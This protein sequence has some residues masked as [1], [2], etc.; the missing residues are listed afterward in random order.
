MAEE[1]IDA[2]ISA[3]NL[4]AKNGCVTAGLLLEGA[5][6]WNEL[7]YIHLVQDYGIETDVAQHLSNTYGDRAFTVAK[8]SKL[9]K[10]RWPIVGTRL[11]VEFPYLESEV[12]Y[13]IRE[14]AMTAVDVLA[15]RLRLAFLNTYAA[16]EVVEEVV[17]IMAAEL[18]W[19][20]AEKRR[21]I[22]TCRRFIDIEMG[23]N[24]RAQAVSDVTLNLTKKEMQVARERFNLLDKDRKGHITVN[25]L[26][27]YFREHGEKIDERLLHELLN[28][29]DLNKNGE[30]EIMEFLQ[31]Y[32]ALKGGQIAQN[33]LVRYLDEIQTSQSIPVG[34][35]GG[36]L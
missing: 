19:S 34:R 31:L 17:Q 15:R 20:D 33:R 14:Y 30:I 27:G 12:R 11:H 23:Q 22:D 24:A 10:K 1:T 8:L 36:G 13:A 32:S 16:H 18:G 3:C 4:K 5:H 21:Q 25:D 6:D 9:T 35:S 29:V 2:A 26:R 28:E 7:Q